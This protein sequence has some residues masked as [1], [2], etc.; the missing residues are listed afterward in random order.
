[1][2]WENYYKNGEKIKDIQYFKGGKIRAEIEYKNG[3]P[4]SGY[5]YDYYSGK[6]TKM[7]NAHF[8]NIGIVY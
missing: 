1:L 5:M 6:K 3:K 2:S 7:T 8:H 4:F